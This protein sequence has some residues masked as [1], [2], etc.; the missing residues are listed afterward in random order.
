MTKLVLNADLVEI[1]PTLTDD[2]L[3]V[4]ANG[5]LLGSFITAEHMRPRVSNEELR[6]LAD[7]K[8][9]GITTAE[10]LASLEKR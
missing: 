4:D 2:V 7:A 9:K 8:E 6:R 5:K 1:L 10:L 3:I